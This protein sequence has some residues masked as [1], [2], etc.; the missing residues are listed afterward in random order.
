MAVVWFKRD[1]RVADHAALAQAAAQGP[2]LPL[3]IVEPGLWREPDAA[4]RHWNFIAE[5]L[6]DLRND[7]A[8]LGM[9][10]VI[11]M[12]DA[13]SVL[14]EIHDAYGVNSLWSHQET[15]N[16]WTF[17][18]DKQVAA[19][20]RGHGIPWHEP[21]QN[22]VIR[23]LRDR[24]G[25]AKSWDA[26]MA[27]PI[28]PSPALAPLSGIALGEIPDAKSL[29][30]ATDL[31]PG[32]QHGGRRQ[33][34]SLLHG[35][36]TD[37][38]IDYRRDMSSPLSGE[39]GCSRLSAHLAWG[40]I[41]MREAAQATYNKMRA[42]KTE[43]SPDAK[44]WRASMTSFSGRLHWH[45]HFM[46]K[47]ESEPR[48]EFANF[49]RAYD[50]LRPAEPDRAKLDAFAAGET[51][52]PFVDACMRFLIASGW[53]NFRMRAMLMSFASYHLWL[54]WRDSG[55]VLARLFTDYEPGI[56]WP[57]TQMQSGTTGINTVRIYNPVKQGYDQDPDGVFVRRW[58]PELA[59][60]PLSFVQEPWTWEA[61]RPLLGRVYPA[62]IVDH[63]AAAKFASDK[64]WG[65]RRGGA[66]RDRADAIQE[67]H[68]SR[69]SGLKPV[70]RRHRS[71]RAKPD[72][73]QAQM[74]FYPN[75]TDQ[76]RHSRQSVS[77]VTDT[78]P[79]N[80]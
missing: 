42:L 5:S 9:P 76:F 65:I 61:V 22:G 63:V 10:L 27:Q 64:V 40:T 66:Y 39:T 53:I 45:C 24:D 35:F 47:L 11:R 28:T 1:L 44:R 59:D 15:G 21:R 31:C 68:G 74:D 57:Q 49:H 13:V 23:R 37:R 17:A 75:P 20:C 36:L 3:Y 7:L 79:Q 19:W 2:V 78:K 14:S 43:P 60:V 6:T 54:P 46:Q 56:H 70:V 32:R 16:G 58:V 55:L 34:V 62:R 25:W 41:S 48:I 52:F 29:G 80:D 4:C 69:K 30:L 26:F 71:S 12:A 33:A 8:R 77:S 51:G 67:K 50:G 18:R 73:N 72:V 38:G